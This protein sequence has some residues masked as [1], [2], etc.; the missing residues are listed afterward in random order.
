VSVADRLHRIS[1]GLLVGDDL[2]A[3]GVPSAR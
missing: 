3:W 2:R 1:A